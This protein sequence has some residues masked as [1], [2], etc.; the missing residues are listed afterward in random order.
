MAPRQTGCPN[1]GSG[2][3]PFDRWFRYPAGF[4]PA[5][6]DRCFGSLSG[7]GGLI[8]DPFAGV[9][10]TGTAAIARG[11]AFRGIE[12]DRKSTRLNSSHQI[13]SYA[14]FCLKKKN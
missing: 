4:S 2:R 5:T 9:A 1:G 6:L 10:T 13:I 7:T 11:H 14:V 3:L 12:T 8:V